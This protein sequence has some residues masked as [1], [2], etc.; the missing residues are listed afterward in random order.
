MPCVVTDFSSAREMVAD[1]K[2]GFVVSGRDEK[3]FS[4]KMVEALG[5]DREKVIEYDK[6]YEKLAVSDVREDMERSVMDE[7]GILKD[8]EYY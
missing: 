1:G 3:V 5:L 7:G 4:Q 2:N 6:R 8:Y